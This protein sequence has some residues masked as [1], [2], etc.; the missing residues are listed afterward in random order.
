MNNLSM[1]NKKQ[2]YAI[3]KGEKNPMVESFNYIDNSTKQIILSLQYDCCWSSGTPSSSGLGH[4]SFKEAVGIRI[5]MGVGYYEKKLI[6]D[7]QEV[8]N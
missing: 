4:I 1:T 5:P 2:L 7:Y 3:I 6:M 8:E